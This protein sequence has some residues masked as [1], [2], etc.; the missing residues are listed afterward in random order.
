[1]QAQAAVA[2]R[3]DAAMDTVQ[4]PLSQAS[5]DRPSA[6]PGAFELPSRHHSVLSSGD[7]SYRGV[8]GGAF[9]THVGT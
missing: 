6:E 4:L 8:W 2:H 7:H 9:W 5:P 3:V 1:M